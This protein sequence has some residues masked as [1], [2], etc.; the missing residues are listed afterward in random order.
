MSNSS[1][2]LLLYFNTS[3]VTIQL[4]AETIPKGLDIISIHLMLLFNCYSSISISAITHFNTS[5]V[6]IQLITASGILSN[7]LN[8][9]TSNVTIQL[10]V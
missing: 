10:V 5:N 2:A 1:A 8:F 9:N 7:F 3:N 4:K 6:T